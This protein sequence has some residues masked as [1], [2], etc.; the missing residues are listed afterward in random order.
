MKTV[1]FGP[2]IGELGWEMLYWQGWVRRVCLEEFRD[3]RKIAA[4][5]PGREP[6]YPYV[7]ELWPLPDYF[8]DLRVSGHGYFT[9]WWRKG[10][11]KPQNTSVSRV[12]RTVATSRGARAAVARALG[13]LIPA[14]LRQLLMWGWIPALRF[15]RSMPD[16]EPF[17]E[18]MLADFKAKLPPDT[19]YFVPWKGNYYVADALEFG[20]TIT[21]R[22][23]DPDFRVVA[24]DYRYQLLERLEPTPTGL[25][26]CRE[27]VPEDSR[28]IA[29]FPRWRTMRRPDKNWPRRRYE[30]L[31]QELQHTFPEF[32]IA[33]LGEPGGAYFSDGVP[34]GCI[35]LINVPHHHRLD[36]QIAALR[37]SVLALGSISGALTVAL[38]AGCPAVMWGY[39]HF[40]DVYHKANFLGTP[41][42]YY[43]EPNPTVEVVVGLARS[44]VYI[45]RK[46]DGSGLRT[47]LSSP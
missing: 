16:V 1:F 24:I 10:I 35:D 12:V 40:L 13:Q 3:Y 17:A 36:I 23:D 32:E 2:F 14:R 31:I 25:E 30:Q 37:Q 18:R 46:G 21:E 43:P 44:C 9:D 20:V 22:T 26:L 38:A 42:I 41:M 28:L 39:S 47:T 29:V 5:F 7:D 6:L 4:S 15:S 27:F 8:L 34:E 45:I 33:I 11:P 19:S